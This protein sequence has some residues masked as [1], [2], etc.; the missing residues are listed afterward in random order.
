ME[1]PVSIVTGWHERCHWEGLN[2]VTPLLCRTLCLRIKVKQ[3]MECSQNKL[4]M[5]SSK[6]RHDAHLRN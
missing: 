1:M 5:N 3:Q 6:N 2:G 4:N